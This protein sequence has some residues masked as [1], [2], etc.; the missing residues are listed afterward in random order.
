MNLIKVRVY[1]HIILIIQ[2]ISDFLNIR[3]EIIRISVILSLIS[4]YMI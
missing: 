1:G 3:L 4:V 2:E